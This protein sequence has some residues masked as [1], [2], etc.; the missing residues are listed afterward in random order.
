M[1]Q[2]WFTVDENSGVA[3]FSPP[4]DLQPTAQQVAAARVKAQTADKSEMK[5]FLS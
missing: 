2:V 3:S 5:L 4:E 1:C